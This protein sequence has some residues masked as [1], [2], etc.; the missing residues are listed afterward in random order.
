MER[1][2]GAG[3]IV[4]PERRARAGAGGSCLAGLRAPPLAW[5]PPGGRG[6]RGE[7]GR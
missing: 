5:L 6:P 7:G 1:S 4:F 3:W 2:L